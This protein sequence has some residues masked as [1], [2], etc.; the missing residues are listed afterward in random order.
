M[1][2]VP[3]R[4][5]SESLSNA[6]K[7]L[8]LMTERGIDPNPINYSVWYHYVA[9][10]IGGL[11]E[12]IEQFLK[13]SKLPITDDVN[14]YLYNKYVM[15]S[16]HKEEAAIKSATDDTQNVLGEIMSVIEKFSGDTESYN[17]QIDSHVTNLSNKILDPALKEMAKEIINQA[18]SI[19][20]SGKDLQL[21]LE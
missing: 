18:V 13:N 8:L 1:Q 6:R 21:K 7:S 19:R 10:D 16:L 2:H 3:Q 4:N 17:N 20:D 5:E 11:N 9:C 12:E 14:I 15:E